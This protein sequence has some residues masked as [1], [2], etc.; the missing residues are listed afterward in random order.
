MTSQ[1]K[2]Q[3]LRSDTRKQVEPMSR[4]TALAELDDSDTT[5]EMVVGAIDVQ[6]F[7]VT[8]CEPALRC[9]IAVR[10]SSRHF[11]VA[12]TWFIMASK[13]F[14]CVCCISSSPRSKK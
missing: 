11:Q 8:F 10:R 13:C 7:T 6:T 5:P 9:S 2:K 14:F 4:I 1:I 12:W 3:T